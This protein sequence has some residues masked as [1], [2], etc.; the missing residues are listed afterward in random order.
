MK[1]KVRYF[2]S[3]REAAGV[4]EED[5]IIE[6]GKSVSEL[7]DILSKKH[8]ELAKFKNHTLFS[9]NRQYA[10]LDTKL[11]ENDELAM[12]PPVSGG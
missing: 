10:N 5:I 9:I 4:H 6:D 1:V 2:A 8:P 7:F 3:H 11:K 12:F